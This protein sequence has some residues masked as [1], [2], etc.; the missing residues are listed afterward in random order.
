MT[1]CQQFWTAALIHLCLGLVRHAL[2][3]IVQAS[4]T[5]SALPALHISFRLS[6]LCKVFRRTMGERQKGMEGS[7]QGDVLVLQLHLI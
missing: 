3:E 7:G 5:T 6:V 2:P 1:V 4:N